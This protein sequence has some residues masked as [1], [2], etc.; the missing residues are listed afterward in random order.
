MEELR[1]TEILDKEIK[2]DARKKAEKILAKAD[3]DCKNM[4]ENVDA[5][6]EKAKK[7]YLAKTEEKLRFFEKDLAASLPLEKKRFLVSF[8]QSSIDKATDAFL[9][10]LSVEEKLEL[11]MRQ[12]QKYENCLKSKKLVVSYYG[13][14]EKLLK[15]AFENKYA[16]VSFNKTD[17][18]KLIIERDC[19]ITTKLGIILE[20]NDKSVRVRTTMSEIICQLQDEYRTE[21]CKTLFDGRLE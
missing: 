6:I 5:R 11:I 19:G 14:E 17:F 18:N 7:D 3:A 21:L 20:A 9:Q 2:A 8:I 16:I 15:K 13:F 1:S 12:I 10:S 4:L